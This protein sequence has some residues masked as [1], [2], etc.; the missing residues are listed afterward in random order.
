MMP[1]FNWFR[2]RSL[3]RGLDRELQYHFDRRVADLSASGIPE[4]EARRRVAAELGLVRLREDVRDVW[5]TRW[6]R[7]FL[8]DL[9]YSARSLRHSPGFTAAVLLSLALGIGA[10]TAIYSLVDQVILHALPVREPGRLVLMDWSG[11]DFVTYATGSSNLMPYPMCREIQQQTRF[12][13]GALC[14]AEIQVNLTAGSD[15]KPVAAE[16]VSG[17]YFSVL[18]VGPALGRVIEPADDA[19]PGAGPV[20]VLSYDFWQAQF[21]GVA[22][23]VGRKVLI[24]NHPMTVVGVAAAGFRGVDVG[25][26]PAFWMPTSMSADANLD[27]TDLMN[28]PVRWLQ[29]LARL[30][31]D[32]TLAQAQTGLQP[33]F[34]A[35]LQDSTLR[36]VFPRLSA[37]HR[38]EYLA[39]TL[40]LTSAP[41]GHSMMRR[42]LAQPLWLLLAATGV[43]LGLACLNVAGLFLARGSARGREIGTR[44]ALGAS[45]GRLGRQLLADSL[46]LAVAGGVLGA[47]VAPIAIRGLIAFLPRDLAAN[48]L[49]PSLSLNL[50]GFALAVSFAAGLLSG[51]APALHAGRD[52]IV[53][54]LRERGGTGFGGVHLRKAIVT[55][56]VAFSLILLIGA[57]LFLRTLTGL[58]AKGPGFETSGLL[59]FAISPTQSGYAPAD[60][61]RLVRRLDQQVRALPVAGSAAAARFAFLNGYAWSN[62][63]TM[64]TDRRSVTDGIINFNAVSPGFFATL[65]IRI[66]AGRDFNQG[67]V[68]PPGEIGPRSAIVNQAFAKR[69]LAGRDPLGVR[70][71]RGGSSDVKPDSVIVGVVAD[72]SYRGVRDHSEQ[73]FFPLFEH[74]DSFATFYVKF[75]GAPDQAISSIR[76]VVRQD[77]PRL[78]ILWFRTLGDQVNRSLT[79]ERLLAALSGS[80]GAL[81]LLLSLIGLYGVMSF[82]VTRRTR[83]IGIRLAL[84]ATRASALRLVLGD[85]VTMI[86]AGVALA[87][88]CIAAL[89]KLVQSQ[90]FGVTATDPATVAA[91]AL[92]LAA[93]ALAAAF[94]PAW[95]AS[96]VS[97]TD[98]LRLE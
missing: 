74:D 8:Y 76:S 23:I 92:V 15:P 54:S 96:N 81:A 98:A 61:S 64:Q 93:G 89:G 69:Y 68:R 37:D 62:K 83:E 12:L 70:I 58:L 28:S 35:W 78:P 18:G 10:T 43:L 59:S 27:E 95:R 9:R 16:I 57:A 63:V 90:L 60:A 56:Q 6:L 2:R 84:G 5:L 26:V 1:L 49:R 66:L 71:A 97:P 73:V 7:D 20:V 79:T 34:K 45:R 17:S 14:R 85:A 86:A 47:A 94:I 77:D 53:N 11:S 32:V 36:P 65:G 38:R 48:A 55:L 19:A 46:L 3:E 82:V 39:T 30:R 72:M 51:L 75:R 13:D 24:G 87:L 40:E 50:L 44:L 33:W 25:A 42:N 4:P 91:A 29:I 21:G 52:H 67:D 41:Q 88:P 31:S 80:F 22:D